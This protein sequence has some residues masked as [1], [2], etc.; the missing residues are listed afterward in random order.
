MEG[1]GDEVAQ[2]VKS[3]TELVPNPEVV[4]VMW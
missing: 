4:A 1:E 3:T 2:G